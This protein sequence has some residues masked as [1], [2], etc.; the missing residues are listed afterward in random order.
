MLPLWRRQDLVPG[1]AH[2]KVIFTGGDC[3]HIVAVRLRTG[4]SALKKINCKSPGSRAP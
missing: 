1:G 4:H 3:R 2:A